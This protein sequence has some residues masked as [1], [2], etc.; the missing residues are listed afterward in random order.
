MS[1]RKVV[2]MFKAKTVKNFLT[3]EQ[4]ELIVN[5]VKDCDL[6]ESVP[7]SSWDKRSIHI[8][9]THQNLDKQIFYIVKEATLKTKQFIESKYRLTAEV[10]PD[11]ASINRWFPGMSQSP[12]A[13]DM[14]NAGVTGY[15]HRVFGS[16]IYLNVDYSGGKTYYPEQNFEITPEV[17]K[18]AVHPGDAEHLHGVTTVEDGMRY[19]ISSF[20]TYQMGRGIDWSLYQ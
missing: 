2:E 12:H 15:E 11:I 4:S 18:L 20:W 1:D 19:T 3:S 13:D 16:I 9:T 7:G 6:W 10:Y 5:A 8:H 17:G 14:I